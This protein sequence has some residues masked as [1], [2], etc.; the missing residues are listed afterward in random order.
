MTLW[1]SPKL[2]AA[3]LAVVAAVTASFSLP[4]RPPALP[5]QEVVRTVEPILSF[6]ERWEPVNLL[7]PMVTRVKTL[8]FMEPQHV[9][10]FAVTKLP[11]VTDT[12]GVVRI[13]RRKVRMEP[14]DNRSKATCNAHGL[15]T[16]WNGRWSWRCQR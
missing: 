12:T 2:I 6:E 1:Q 7:P 14:A 3:A 11:I 9:S 4:F 5:A 15:R 13:E 16:V 10:D 8:S